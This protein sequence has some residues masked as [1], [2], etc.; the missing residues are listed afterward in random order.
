MAAHL[1]KRLS[2]NEIEVDFLVT[3]D[4]AAGPESGRLDRVISENTK[5]NLNVIQTTPSALGSRGGD[6]KRQDGSKNGVNN[7]IKVTYMDEKGKKRRMSHG[8]IDEESAQEVIQEILR[9]LNEER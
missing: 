9:K 5:E 1:E 8:V 6:N 4:A 7:R 3:V 2:Q